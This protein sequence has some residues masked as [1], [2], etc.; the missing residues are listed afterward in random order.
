MDF[1]ADCHSREGPHHSPWLAEV[2]APPRPKESKGKAAKAPK[3]EPAEVPKC[4]A[5]AAGAIEVA[6]GE[7]AEVLKDELSNCDIDGAPKGGGQN[8]LDGVP[9]PARGDTSRWAC[10]LLC[11]L[12]QKIQ[13]HV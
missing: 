2:V 9:N 13:V 6:E 5:W 3:A 1:V 10:K 12:V 8:P 11:N 4:V 7:A